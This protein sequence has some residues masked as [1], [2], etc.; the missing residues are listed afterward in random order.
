MSAVIKQIRKG[1][2]FCYTDIWLFLAICRVL[3][4]PED[5]VFIYHSAHSTDNVMVRWILTL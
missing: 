5:V 3:I 2:R 4:F 1:S